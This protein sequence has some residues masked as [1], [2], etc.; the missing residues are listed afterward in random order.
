[1]HM[2]HWM[3]YKRERKID[4]IQDSC[5]VVENGGEI[6][7]KQETELID[8]PEQYSIDKVLFDDSADVCR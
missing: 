2:K 1:M 8:V 4:Y 5:S 7:M 3:K 6:T